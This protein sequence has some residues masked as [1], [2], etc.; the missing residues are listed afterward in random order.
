MNDQLYTIE[1]ARGRLGGISRN[2]IYRLLR[3]GELPSVVIGCRRFIAAAA[4]AELI[5]SRT[6]TASPAKASTRTA[7]RDVRGTLSLPLPI[8]PAARRVVRR[9]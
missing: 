3:S 9:G 6:T 4:L 8:T 5:K 7:S 1:E 2:G